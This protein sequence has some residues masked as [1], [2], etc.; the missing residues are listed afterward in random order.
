MRLD[1][2]YTYPTSNRMPLPPRSPPAAEEEA[3][4]SRTPQVLAPRGAQ[5]VAADGLNVY[6]QLQGSV[7]QKCRW[8]E[9]E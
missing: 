3:R 9:V 1:H 5:E 6:W 2:P 4:T 8:N 7:H